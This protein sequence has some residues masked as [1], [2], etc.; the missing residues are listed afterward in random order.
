MHWLPLPPSQ[1]SLPL[2]FLLVIPEG[3]LLLPL[4][5]S[6]AWSAVPGDSNH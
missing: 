2:H 4:S 1:L 5:F 6:R 3:D